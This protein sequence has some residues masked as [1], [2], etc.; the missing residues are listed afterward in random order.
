MRGPYCFC[1]L[2]EVHVWWPK[3]TPKFTKIC[4]SQLVINF[5]SQH[6]WMCVLP[7]DSIAPP[8]AG[9]CDQ[10]PLVFLK[11]AGLIGI[12]NIAQN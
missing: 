1:N 2:K 6:N 8:K 7:G 9:S 11:F 12:I 4:T 3:H 10:K 5:M